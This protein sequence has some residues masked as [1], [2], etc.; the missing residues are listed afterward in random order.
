MSFSLDDTKSVKPRIAGLFLMPLRWVCAWILFAAAWRRLVLK[1]ES[2]NPH[3]PLFE[4]I[5]INHFLPHTLWI[6]GF[7]NILVMHPWAMLAFLWVFTMVEAI[8]GIL[9]FIGLGTRFLGLVLI[10]L[11]MNLMLVA[12]WLG[13][14]CLD[15]WTVATFGITLG[16]C[17]FL[18][19]SGPFSVD[20][21]LFRKYTHL[22]EHHVW[23]IFVSPELSFI[24]DY[25]RGK[26]LAIILSILTLGFV[27]YTNQYF[28]GG[29]Y[30]PFKNPAVAMDIKAHAALQSN[31]NL[32]LTIYRNQGPDTYG[33]FIVD[34]AV[35]T[36]K[37]QLLE[38]YTAADLGHLAP[39]AVQNFY[40]VKVVPNGNALVLP[41]GGL[42]T[43]QLTP[44]TPISLSTGNYFVTITDV[45]G[46]TWQTTGAVNNMEEKFNPFELMRI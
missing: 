6:H 36:R 27:L 17:L 18:A 46:K 9:L 22:I 11:F 7:L 1:P 14:T 25:R 21:L 33:A 45:S 15:E 3:S 4:G 20:S 12:G 28:V 34:I 38:N 19:G 16:A 37:G 41:L 32:T 23:G 8:A 2:L 43:L 40:L 39:S 31:G 29:V 10:L 44:K 26:I 5:K 30:G 35:K 24:H 42:A 13:S